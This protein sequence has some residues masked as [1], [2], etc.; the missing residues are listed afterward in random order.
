MSARNTERVGGFSGGGGGAQRTGD[1]HTPISVVENSGTRISNG[2]TGLSW[3]GEKAF[4]NFGYRFNEGRYGIPFAAELTAEQTPPQTGTEQNSEED[5]EGVD[6]DFRRHHSR[7]IGGCPNYVPD[8]EEI[9]RLLECLDPAARRFCLAFLNSGFR[10]SELVA[11]NVGDVDLEKRV[12]RVV[13][14]GAK[15]RKIFMNAVLCDSIYAEIQSRPGVGPAE[16]LFLNREKKRYRSL[17]T[18]LATACKRVKVTRISHHSLPR[19]R[20]PTIRTWAGHRPPLK[21]PGTLHTN[22]HSDYLRRGPRGAFESFDSAKLLIENHLASR[23]RVAELVD[24]QD[25]KS[26]GP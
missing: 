8:Q 25:L 26:W 9:Y 1:Y 11:F 6:I 17:R 3:Y 24:A 4:V 18:P 10:K 22:N 19:I 21:S 7:L 5:L 14:K 2:T 13:G 12:S 15:R 20:N 16:P 23:A